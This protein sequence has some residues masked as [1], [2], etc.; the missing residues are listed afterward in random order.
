V[1]PEVERARAL[2]E[3]A[4]RIAVISREQPDGDA[5]IDAAWAGVSWR[6]PSAVPVLADLP[7]RHGSACAADVITPRPSPTCWPPW[8]A[9]N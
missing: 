6:G 3:G 9:L 2:L 5:G 4:H 7:P 1:D 8:I